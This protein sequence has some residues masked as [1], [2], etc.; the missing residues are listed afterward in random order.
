MKRLLLFTMAIFLFG[1]VMAQF[2]VTMNVDM[3]ELEGF[4][5]ETHSVYV[6]GSIFGWPEPGTN[7][8]LK[9]SQ[10]EETLIYTISAEMEEAGEIQYKYFSDAVAAGWAG[11]EWEGDPN[12][13]IFATGEATLNDLWADQPFPVTFNVDMSQAEGFNPDTDE[14]FMAGT[15]NVA[16]NWQQP[17]T[18]PSLLM[19]AG[20]DMVYSLTL[21]LYAGDYMYKYFRVIDGTP[22]WD[23]GEW[24]GD[25]NRE[26]SVMEEVTFNDVW[27]VQ[28]GVDIDGAWKIAYEAGAI[29]VGPGQGDISGW[30]NSADDLTIR[31]CYFDDKYVFG[32]DGAFM[33]EF[34]GETWVEEWQ[35]NDPPGCAAP[36]APHDGSNPA[37]WEFD[38]SAGTL[39][40]NGVGA[41]LGLAKVFN[42]GEL[43][44]PGDA[45]ESITYIVEFSEND[46]RMTVDIEIA[47]GGWWR[48]ILDKV[49]PQPTAR[50][51]V[52]HNAAD[53]AAEV[54][55][56][57]LDDLLLLDNFTFR[58]ASP[59]VDAPAGVE[60]TIAIKGP[61]SEDP[62]DPI[63]SHPYTLE[64]GETYI[65]IANGIINE[66]AYDPYKPFDIYVC[67]MGR[68]AAT[69]DENVDV[70]VFHGSTDAPTVSVYETS[71]DPAPLIEDFEYGA[72]AG[73]LELPTADYVLQVR[74]AEGT[75]EVATYGAPLAE[76][77]LGGQ[78]L[79]VVASGFLNPAN[80]SDGPLFSLWVA[81]AE[82]GA[83]IE[84]PFLS[85]INEISA[86]TPAMN[87]YP[88]PAQSSLNIQL[89]QEVDKLEVFNVIGERIMI[90]DQINSEI[91]TINTSSLSSGVYFITVYT[92][93]DVQTTKFL[94]N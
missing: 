18:D 70:L 32:V 9:L 71:N 28:P 29:G 1:G 22:S 20:E 25:P 10:V 54:V 82:G 63:W 15:I 31:A 83:L 11:G 42:G 60:F 6:S 69:S 33:N 67:A 49:M 76:L 78:A 88:N 44:S 93:N 19:T 73:Y 94:K 24:L 43:T 4:D 2:S 17:G 65:L 58:N 45:P 90:I 52:I 74:N 23:N 8:N 26:V 64:D 13:K 50:V 92:G 34:D 75:A 66:E 91:I 61:D 30:S 27:A 72:F 12:R 48:F 55:D 89:L 46:T 56:V 35:G 14:V 79:T 39:T 53:A 3:S 38:Q 68:E 85:S 7:E 59:F 5:P 37:T 40:L 51:Q 62:S 86:S 21:M 36:V 81:L 77:G 87:I 47:D 41:F 57:W 80:N 84:L 16:N